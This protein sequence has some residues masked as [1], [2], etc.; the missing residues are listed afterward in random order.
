MKRWAFQLIYFLV[1]ILIIHSNVLGGTSDTV[2]TYVLSDLQYEVYHDFSRIIFSTNN[3]I[4]FTHYEL[5]EPYRIVIDLLGVSFCELQEHIE[6]DQGLVRSI[7]IVETPYTRKPEGLDEYFYAVDYIIITPDGRPPYSVNSVDQG[8]VIVL[9]I[10]TD[11]SAGKDMKVPLS[12]EESTRVMPD[13]RP[14]MDAVVPAGA[15]VA[16]S[17]APERQERGYAP[18]TDD[19]VLDI[20]SVENMDDSILTILSTRTPALFEIQKVSKP[21]HNITITPKTAVFTDIENLVKFDSSLIRSIEIVEDSSISVPKTLD[22]YHYPVKYIAIDADDSLSLSAYSNDDETVLILELSPPVISMMQDESRSKARGPQ[23]AIDGFGQVMG[24]EQQADIT[25]PVAKK[26]ELASAKGPTQSAAVSRT[27]EEE[28]K[29][30]ARK[31]LLTMFRD[32]IRKES[33]VKQERI[34]EL[35]KAELENRKRQARQKAQSIGKEVLKELFVDG[36]GTISLSKSRLIA[37]ENNPQAK[38]A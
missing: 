14:V 13:I 8:K 3:G 1:F 23:T 6:Y 30:I 17:Q 38:T 5:Y 16:G 9:D 31:E 24:E 7:D 35:K 12:Q 26:V 4:G 27:E 2:S 20:V 11:I 29:E 28:L 22:K 37:L 34:D 25:L 10:G 18:E 36:K 32:E 19:N 33:L 21:G 15:V